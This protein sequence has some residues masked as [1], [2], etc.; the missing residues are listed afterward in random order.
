MDLSTQIQELEDMVREAKSMPLSSSVLVHR[1]DVLAAIEEMRHTLPDEIQQ[2]RTVVRDR[3]GNATQGLD[4]NCRAMLTCMAG[5]GVK[6]GTVYGA[7]D[8]FGYKSI[9]VLAKLAKEAK[10]IDARVSGGITILSESE[11][12]T[13][14]FVTDSFSQTGDASVKQLDD[15]RLLAERL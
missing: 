2:A 14:P 15:Q 9:E 12:I 3:N 4:H 8:E 6:G 13:V 5:G 1:E 7:T 10:Q 11:S